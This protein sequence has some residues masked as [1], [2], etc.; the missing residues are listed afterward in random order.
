MRYIN[1]RFTCILTSKL[2]FTNHKMFVRHCSNLTRMLYLVKSVDWFN[3]RLSH[4]QVVANLMG[5][6]LWT[7]KLFQYI[8]YIRVNSVFHPYRIGK[9]S[10][11]LSG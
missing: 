3:S 4:F 5:V 2:Q 11:G 8:T 1:L 9:S 6:C 10:I 7:S